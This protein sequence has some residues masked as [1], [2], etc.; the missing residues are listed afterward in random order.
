MAARRQHPL[1][2]PSTARGQL[3]RQ[4]LMEAAIQVIEERGIAEARVEEITRR[5]GCGYGTFYKYFSSKIDLVR[6]VMTE[7]YDEIHRKSFPLDSDQEDLED[8]VRTGVT[9]MVEVI[10][11]HRKILLTL[12]RAVGLDSNLLE[13]RN[14]LLHRD[15]EELERR[16]RMLE[17]AGYGFELDPFATSL[18]LNGMVEETARRWLLYEDRLSEEVFIATIVGIFSATL[19]RKKK[20]REKS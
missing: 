14:R 1:V 18:A 6:Q 10:K 8:L 12:E 19:L 3:T 13:L 4:R 2:I 11:K 15:V 9:N 5:V 7:V 20:V 16:I 17:D